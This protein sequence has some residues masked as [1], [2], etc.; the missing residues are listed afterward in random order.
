MK[1]RDAVRFEQILTRHLPLK[2]AVL[3]LDC[4]SISDA[5]QECPACTSRALMNLSIV[6]NPQQRIQLPAVTQSAA[7]AYRSL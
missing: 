7:V 1:R 4:S 5:N 6:L 2:K 3:C